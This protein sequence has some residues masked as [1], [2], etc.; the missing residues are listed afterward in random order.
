MSFDVSGLSGGSFASLDWTSAATQAA[1]E[2]QM[3]ATTQVA[4][5]TQST[6][7]PG[8]AALTLQPTHPLLMV[9]TTPLTPTV[10]AELI[11]RQL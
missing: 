11:G 2:N 1:A 4:G 9:P 3:A 6:G 5:Q 8:T 7:G 10:L